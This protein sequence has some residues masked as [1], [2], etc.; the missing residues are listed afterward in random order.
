MVRSTQWAGDIAD[1][2]RCAGGV[3]NS[4]LAMQLQ[5]NV[6]DSFPSSL[7]VQI[8]GFK[9]SRPSMRESTALG[10]ALLAA[11]ALGLFGWDVSNPSTLENVNTAG[12][13]I[14]EPELP[15]KERKKAVKGWEKAVKRARHWYTV[16]EEDEVEGE[17]EKES[18]VP[19]V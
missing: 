12:V 13:N 17:F 3:T 6:S 10:S 14:F 18:G 4:D 1:V 7:S 8:G 11:H 5:A 16:E 19:K 9:V 2:N 15:E